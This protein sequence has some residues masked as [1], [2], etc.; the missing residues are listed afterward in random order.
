MD[1]MPGAC[2]QLPFSFNSVGATAVT[3]AAISYMAA[4]GLGVLGYIGFGGY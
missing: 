4:I 1:L 3:V 2:S